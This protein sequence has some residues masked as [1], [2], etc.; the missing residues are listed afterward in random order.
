[1]ML[2]KFGDYNEVVREEIGTMMNKTTDT[3]LLFAL[4]LKHTSCNK[5]RVREDGEEVG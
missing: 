5:I 4:N 2:M 1:M 3:F